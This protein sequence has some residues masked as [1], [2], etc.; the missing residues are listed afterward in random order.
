MDVEMEYRG[1]VI[2]SI[3]VDVGHIGR[4]WEVEVEMEYRGRGIRGIEVEVRW[5]LR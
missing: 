4:S 3:E 5:K 1:R 2:R